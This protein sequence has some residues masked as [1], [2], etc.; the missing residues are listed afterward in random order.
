MNVRSLLAVAAAAGLT[1]AAAC[2]TTLQAQT[3]ASSHLAVPQGINKIKHVIII[4]QENRSYD[5]Y[6][7]KYP[8][9]GG[10]PAGAC[11]PDPRAHKCVKPYTDHADSNAGGPHHSSDSAADV[12][13]GKMDGFIRND[14]KWKTKHGQ[15]K[16]KPHVCPT[17]VMGYHTGSDIPNYWAYAHN[18]V[19]LTHLYEP[20]HSWSLPMHLYLASGWSASC[21]NHNPMECTNALEPQG[22]S[23]SDPTPFAWTSLTFL[24]NK[25][26][27]KWGWYVDHGSAKV[28]KIWNVLPGFTDFHKGKQ[29]GSVQPLR[30]NFF[31]QAKNNNL[32]AVSWVLPDMAD[33]E[34]PRAL[35]STGQAYVTK[36]IN[37]VMASKEWNS[38]AIFL[39]WDDWGG[40]YDHVPLTQV[41]T[42]GY[43]IRVPGI[44]ISPYARRGVPDPQTLSTDAYLKFIEDNFLNGARLDPRTDGRPD[45]RPI[46]REELPKSSSAT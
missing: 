29:F 27:V 28:P 16:P 13:G 31:S 9:P 25:F 8:A 34:H 15:C 14:Q 26:H 46:V 22:I 24:L 35:V 39:A 4:M 38:S 40:F 7:G 19:L 11:V 6:F 44:V 32:P 37:A 17:D 20:V 43:G 5:S 41:D 30:P 45:S 36:I 21:K 18:F 12:D 1:A 10:I 2:G 42:E 23:K 33:S 3:T